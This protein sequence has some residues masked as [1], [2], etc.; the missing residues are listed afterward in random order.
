MRALSITVKGLISLEAVRKPDFVFLE[1][2]TKGWFG[3]SSLSRTE[4]MNSISMGSFILS[5]I[6][7][8]FFTLDKNRLVNMYDGEELTICQ[9]YLR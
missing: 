5:K 8:W 9:Y 3:S 7:S 4:L 1:V 6:T 2:A